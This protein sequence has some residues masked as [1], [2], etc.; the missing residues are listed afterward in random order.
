[1]RRWSDLPHVQASDSK[2]L[3]TLTVWLS[4][5]WRVK[6]MNTWH[7]LIPPDSDTARS[8]VEAHAMAD[9]QDTDVRDPT[10]TVL[11]NSALFLLLMGRYATI[12]S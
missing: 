6:T 7:P 1:M 12:P 3:H 4:T 5:A 10:C 11:E 8:H 2:T 9:S